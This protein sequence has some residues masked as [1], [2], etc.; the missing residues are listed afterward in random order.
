MDPW[1]SCQARVVDID[2]WVYSSPLPL[3]VVYSP[4]SSFDSYPVS[5]ALGLA[6]SF[7]D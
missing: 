2:A 1:Q 5:H 7:S 6:L 3:S 4:L